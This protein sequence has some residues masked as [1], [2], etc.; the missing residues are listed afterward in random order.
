MMPGM[1]GPELRAR[2]AYLLPTAR[3]LFMS[4]YTDQA[5]LHQGIL[6]PGA[7]FLQKPFTPEALLL[8]VREILDTPLDRAA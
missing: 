6:G 4:G 7:P 5:I 8:K 3:F 2:L 1:S